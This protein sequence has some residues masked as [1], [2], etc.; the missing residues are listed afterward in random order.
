MP[1]A[2]PPVSK[3]ADRKYLNE[4]EDAALAKLAVAVA[5]GHEAVRTEQTKRAEQ[6]NAEQQKRI[7]ANIRKARERQGLSPADLGAAAGIG[8]GSIT[9]IEAGENVLM[10]TLLTVATALGVTLTDLVK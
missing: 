2:D 6:A 7:G 3:I 1:Y 8:A 10:D 4:L 5:A 9:R